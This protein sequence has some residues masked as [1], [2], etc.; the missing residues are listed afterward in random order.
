VSEEIKGRPVVTVASRAA[1]RDWLEAHHGQAEGVWLATYKKHHPDHL[2]W[3]EAIE[4]LI[5]FGWIDAVVQRVDDDRSAHLVAPRKPGSAWSAVNKEIV[6][7]MR[8][9]GRMTPPGEAAIAVAEANGMWA[10]L[11]DV[12]R[13]EVPG[14]LAEAL[15]DLRAGLGRAGPG[16]LNAGRWSGSRRRRRP[17]T[18]QA[19]RDVVESAGQGLRPSPF[20]AVGGG[21]FP[22]ENVGKTAVFPAGPRVFR[23]PRRTSFARPWTCL[24]ALE[25]GV[26]CVFGER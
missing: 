13:L 19:D 12:E 15:G 8:A 7:R 5:C 18:G 24:G 14:D 20:P 21:R 4:E 16:R 25:W 2:P 23:L 9:E 22:R 1:L 6:A 11:D 10:F 26:F 3:L 17:D